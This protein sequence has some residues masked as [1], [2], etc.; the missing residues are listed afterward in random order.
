MT[1][2]VSKRRSA[3]KLTAA[4]I[5]STHEN[6]IPLQRAQTRKARLTSNEM[7]AISL[8]GSV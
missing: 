4:L 5:G 8:M 7:M 6:S 2:F 1:A 3:V